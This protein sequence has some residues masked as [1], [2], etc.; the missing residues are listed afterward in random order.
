MKNGT[1]FTTQHYSNTFIKEP[2]NERLHNKTMKFYK[3]L[4]INHTNI[5]GFVYYCK[6]FVNRLQLNPVFVIRLKTFNNCQNCLRA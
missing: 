5:I 4:H 1:H 6:G 2:I 3:R